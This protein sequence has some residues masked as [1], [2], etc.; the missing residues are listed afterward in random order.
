MHDL[1]AL[2]EVPWP[3]AS[4][5]KL[6]LCIHEWPRPGSNSMLRFYMLS[7][8][9]CNITT[10]KHVWYPPSPRLIDCNSSL[11]L[12]IILIE[13]LAPT[14]SHFPID[15][16]TT[17]PLQN[18]SSLI[19]HF[20]LSVISSLADPHS[21]PY[22]SLVVVLAV[23]LL[24]SKLPNALKHRDPNLLDVA[25][26]LIKFFTHSLDDPV[27]Y[28]DMETRLVPMTLYSRKFLRNRKRTWS[29]FL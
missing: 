22:C 13:P 11:R 23:G 18:F 26:S 1:R 5:S 29:R 7:T 25:V 9:L 10:W 4:S 12:R 27:Q 14:H 19:S 17:I 20:S 28:H 16:A 15:N 24:P 3:P 2:F 21:S 6:M 8:M